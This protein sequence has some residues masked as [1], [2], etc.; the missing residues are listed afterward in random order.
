[1]ITMRKLGPGL[2]KIDGSNS[3]HTFLSVSISIRRERVF[4]FAVIN[5]DWIG[6]RRVSAPIRIAT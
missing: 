3:R 4:S 6:P 5:D 1:M 2:T